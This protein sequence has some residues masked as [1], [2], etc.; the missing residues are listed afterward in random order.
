MGRIFVYEL[1]SAGASCAAEPADAEL[2]A[3]GRA[4][5]DAIVGDLLRLSGLHVTCAVGGAPS[6]PHRPR[7][8]TASP[9]P[10]EPPAAFVQRLARQH[11][12]SWVVAPET[13]GM[14]M[15]LHDA[16]G[17]ARWMGCSAAAIRIASSKRATAALL[18]AHGIA[19]PLAAVDAQRWVV[20]PDDGA[21][22]MATRVHASRPAALDDLRRREGAGGA[23][24]LEPFVEG[25]PLSIS[26]LAGPHRVETVALNRQQLRI[27]GEGWIHDLGVHSHAVDPRTDP[28]APR[29]QALGREVARALPGL[30]GFVGIDLVW[31]ERRGPVVIE[32]NPRTTCA[33][34]G[35]SDKLQRNL[36]ADVLALHAARKADD[37]VAA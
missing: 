31:N 18:D 22:A 32:V 10:G 13:N 3:A 9:R 33:Y 23:A 21:G 24:T 25:E 1:L 11:D 5:R 34:V 20:K 37:A 17:A 2:L 28:R 8:T 6:F 19:T 4:M 29:L 12:A 14:L 30:G 7:L 26:L 36:A 16:V 35:L 15:R 27:D